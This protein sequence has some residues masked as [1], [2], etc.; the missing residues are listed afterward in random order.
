[1]KIKWIPCLLALLTLFSSLAY[2]QENTATWAA[3][4]FEGPYDY[5]YED[6]DRSIVIQKITGDQSAGLL[7]DVQLREAAGFHAGAAEGD[8]EALSSMAQREGA[9]LAINADDYGTH[10][11]GVIIRDGQC[12]RVHDTTRHMLAVLPDGSFETVSDRTSQTPEELAQRLQA[13][14]VMHTFE[15]GP[16]LVENGEA[17]AFPSSFDV[18]STR[19]S[20]REPRTAIGMI[21]PLHYVI[22]VVDGRQSGYSEGVSL[23]TLQQ[24]FV[25]LG[26]QT[27]FNLDGGGSSEVWFQGE[28]LNRPAGGHERK[29]SDCI[30]F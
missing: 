5:T 14:N 20:R 25:N 29:L 13:E 17:V 4:C 30:W 22:V 15:F 26:V 16:V 24:L 28:I 1:M 19:E 9:V 3:P 7:I 2:A 10:K 18:I 23:Q 11:Y 27:A 12:L 21:S 8:F 6:A